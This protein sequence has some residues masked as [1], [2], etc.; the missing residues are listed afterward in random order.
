MAIRPTVQRGGIGQRLLET[1][2]THPRE[3]GFEKLYLYTTFVLPG[4]TR[5]YEKNG[6]YVVRETAPE[7]WYGMGGIEMEKT[8]V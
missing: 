7:E 6:F 2:E 5:L 3:T 8:L 4:A 1:L